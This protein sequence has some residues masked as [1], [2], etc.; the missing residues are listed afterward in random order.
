LI[1]ED[2]MNAKS[3]LAATVMAG[4]GL[5]LAALPAAA[6][7]PGGGAVGPGAGR[8]AG[9]G[10]PGLMMFEWF[11]ADD[12]GQITFEEFQAGGAKRFEVLDTDKNG[13]LTVQEL[14]A[15]RQPRNG[16]RRQMMLQLADSNGDGVISKQEFTEHAELRFESLDQDG[17][18][19]ITQGELQQA[20]AQMRRPGMGPG[21]GPS[22]GMGSG[23]GMGPG[24]GGPQGAGPGRTQQ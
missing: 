20:R 16:G 9:A 22:Q 4:L 10:T 5:G 2:E 21:G 19:K 14:T 6:Q 24:G 13:T 15:W 11:D 12:S 18:G 3:L 17:D 1:K 23:Q 7:D 8:G